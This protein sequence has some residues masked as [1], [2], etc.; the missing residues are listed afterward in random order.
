MATVIDKGNIDS[1][2]DKPLTKYNRTVA[3]DPN[4]S[5]TPQFSGEIVLDL[6]SNVLWQAQSVA[7]NTWVQISP[8]PIG[9]TE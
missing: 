7:N 1:V 4:Q 6:T 8:Y 5:E 2:L 9:Q 3:D